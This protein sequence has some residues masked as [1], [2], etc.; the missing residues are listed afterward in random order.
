MV[1]RPAAA[2]RAIP[3]ISA[4]CAMQGGESSRAA[5]FVD[6]RT[7]IWHMLRLKTPQGFA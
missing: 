7:G 4:L 3:G 1:N 6:T 5:P 2:E